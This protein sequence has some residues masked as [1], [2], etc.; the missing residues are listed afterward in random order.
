M[1]IMMMNSEYAG[2]NATFFVLHGSVCILQ[3][4]LQEITGYSQTWGTNNFWKLAN[5]IVT[6]SLLLVTSP[7]F[8]IPF[9][10]SGLLE[11]IPVPLAFLDTVKIEKQ[12]NQNASL[13]RASRP[14]LL[15]GDE[16]VKEIRLNGSTI[17]IK[18]NMS[19]SV[20]CNLEIK[21][22]QDLRK[23]IISVHYFSHS[24]DSGV[25]LIKQINAKIPRF[26]AIGSEKSVIEIWLKPVDFSYDL[27]NYKSEYDPE[28]LLVWIIEFLKEW[29]KG[30]AETGKS[31]IAYNIFVNHPTDRFI[32]GSIFFCKHDDKRKRNPNFVIQ[33]MAWNL[34]V[35]F[36]KFCA[37]LKAVMTDD[38]QA[39]REGKSS[40]L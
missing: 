28:T 37:H 26:A 9:A 25:T 39:A 32:I 12:L 6:F 4:H 13:E 20:N 1:R 18:R 29:L 21:H 24:D 10:K 15:K 19:T 17:N 5:W 40:I 30:G 35:I 14:V 8:V 27:A 33:T 23:P 38:T 11:T 34:S 3:I 22:V 16:Q 7:T 31:I 36:P 2:F